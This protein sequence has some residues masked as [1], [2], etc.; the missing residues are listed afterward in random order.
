MR[1]KIFRELISV[2]EALS[3]LFEAVKPSRRV[4]E[5]SLVDCL[6]RVLAVDVYAPRDIPPFDRAA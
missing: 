1:R 2:E 3:R 4:E 5:V 6:G